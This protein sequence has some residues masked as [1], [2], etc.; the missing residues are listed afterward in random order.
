MGRVLVALGRKPSAIQRLWL[1]LVLVGG[2]S[3]YLAAGYLLS[4]YAGASP[5]AVQ[6]ILWVGWL[7]WLR[8]GFPRSHD[9]ATGRAPNGSYRDAFYAQI[10]PGVTCVLAQLL[11][12][13]LH[14]VLALPS[15]APPPG[16]LA[17]SLLAI[18]V[19]VALVAAATRTLGIGGV[20]F[21]DEYGTA[22]PSVVGSSVYAFLRHPLFV[23]GVIVSVGLGL[24]G[25]EVSLLLAAM[26]VVALPFYARFEDARCARVFG[27]RHEDHR[28]SVR[29]PATRRARWRVSTPAS[30]CA[31]RT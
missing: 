5:I 25:G 18:L 9:A 1:L 27:A 15:G 4:V 7:V 8:W 3:S 11:R 22:P 23:G 2:A 19:G 14:A 20:L 30:H 31:A 13:G 6:A 21:V 29:R 17:V 28:A 26:N 16:T 24:L 12:P 10:L